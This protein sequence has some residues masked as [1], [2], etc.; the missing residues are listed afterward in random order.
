MDTESIRI[1]AWEAYRQGPDGVVE[2]V[3]QLETLAERVTDLEAENAA[4]RARLGTNSRNSGKP[5]SSDGP[6]IKPHPKSLRTPT[7]RKSGAQAGHVGHTLRLVDK[8]D[9]VQ[10]HAPS[11]CKACGRSL[12]QVLATRR[13]RRQ[14]MDIPAVKVRVSRAPERAEH[15]AE[16]KCCPSCLAA[17]SRRGPWRA[18]W[19][20]ATRYWPGSKRRSSRRWQGRA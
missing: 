5:P 11:Q 16:T 17:R 1:K 18:P 4:L 13:E 20:H 12:E 3:A 10:V 15:Q 14:V 7:G 19:V 9:E 2:L 8:A 6:G